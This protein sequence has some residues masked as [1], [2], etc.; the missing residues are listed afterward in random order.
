MFLLGI[1]FC[2]LI[3]WEIKFGTAGG[4][5]GSFNISSAMG[6]F[7]WVIVF[8]LRYVFLIFYEVFIAARTA[9][10]G[11]IEEINNSAA[12]KKALKL[13]AASILIKAVYGIVWGSLSVWLLVEIFYLSY[14]IIAPLVLDTSKNIF[15]RV[16]LPGMM[17][18][19]IG[20]FIYLM[21]TLF[22]S[23]LFKNVFPKVSAS[24]RLLISKSDIR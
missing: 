3:Y 19:C 10:A 23:D 7:L 17:I 9:F 16:F 24:C 2:G 22:F 21:V 1:A 5:Y 6:G 14:P 12:S 18:M 13:V 15:E 8:Q 11:N 20:V 4:S